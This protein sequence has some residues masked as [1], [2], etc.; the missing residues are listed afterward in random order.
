[1]ADWCQSSIVRNLGSYWFVVII[2]VWKANIGSGT[3]DP[4]YTSPLNW[5]N[6]LSP[7]SVDKWKWGQQSIGR[8]WPSMGCKGKGLLLY[9]K[10][11]IKCD[12]YLH[13]DLYVIWLPHLQTHWSLPHHQYFT[14][15]RYSHKPRTEHLSPYLKRA[16]YHALGI[17]LRIFS[18]T[19]LD[20][21]LSV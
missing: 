12:F 9:F 15:Y 14:S 20:N 16:S 21:L 2:V 11:G 13:S 1:M 7:M 6:N 18:I 17:P 3:Q 10:M 4:D 8:P 19:S 5:P